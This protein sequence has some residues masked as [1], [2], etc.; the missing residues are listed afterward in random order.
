MFTLNETVQKEISERKVL[1][2]LQRIK[3][4]KK[5][6]LKTSKKYGESPNL[7]ATGK[8]QIIGYFLFAKGS[9]F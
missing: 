6:T 9:C 5:K 1:K 2:G 8:I 3:L 7:Y 4:I